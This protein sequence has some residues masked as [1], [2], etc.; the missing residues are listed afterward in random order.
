MKKII[1]IIVTASILAVTLSAPAQTKIATVDVKK[2][3]NG[4]IKTKQ[5]QA[6]L[7]KQKADLL[8]EIK[9][10]SDGLDKAKADYRK[11]LDQA[12]DQALS[13]DERAKRQQAASDK[14]REINNSQADLQ[15]R[16]RQ[17]DTQYSDQGQRMIS[18]LYAEIQKKVAAKAKADGY[19]LVLNSATTEVVV[20]SDPQVDITAAVL[21]QLNAGL[22]IDTTPAPVSMLNISTNAP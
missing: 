10:M 9:D 4:Y 5:A 11:L 7:D 22:P 13:A 15:Q 1:L 20:Y 2:L 8:K 16:Q 18:N 21:A 12:S 19:T 17:A 6:A 14:A 3:F